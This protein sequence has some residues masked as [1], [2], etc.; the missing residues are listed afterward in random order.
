MIRRPDQVSTSPGDDGDVADCSSRRLSFQVETSPGAGNVAGVL[1]RLCEWCR[2]SPLE[3]TQ[4]RWC[5]TRCRQTAWRSRKLLVAED[6]SDTPKRLAY[7]DPPYPG[8]ARRYYQ[9]EPNY[10]GEVDHEALIAKLVQY[11]GWALSTSSKGL[12]YVL[13]LCPPEVRVASWVKPD[14]VSSKT[15]GA[16]S[17]WEPILYVPA[18]LRR[19]G[20]RDWLS[21]KAARGNGTLPGRKPL[22]FC[23]FLFQLLGAS[24]DD[25]LDDLFPGTG[26][27]SAA[28]REF[29]RS[30]PS[31]TPAGTASSRAAHDDS[32][33]RAS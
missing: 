13:P 11:D 27:V 31:L 22:K 33:R 7:G 32:E 10:A 23:A 8:L 25:E 15:R 14:G 20:F 18:R 16:H 5:S 6:P 21:A 1:L 2:R 26:I 17:K 19:P 4:E 24:P 9:G 28:F 29:R 12:R 3:V 30:A